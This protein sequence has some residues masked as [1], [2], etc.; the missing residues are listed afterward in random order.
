VEEKN[1]VQL[2]TNKTYFPDDASERPKKEK[3]MAGRNK[4]LEIDLPFY[5]PS[6]SAWAGAL[7]NIRSCI[8]EEDHATISIESYNVPDLAMFAHSDHKGM[9]MKHWLRTRESWI[10]RVTCGSTDDPT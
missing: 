2:C 9:F 5:L 7:A 3:E 8:S 6:V 4:F 1:P 10:W